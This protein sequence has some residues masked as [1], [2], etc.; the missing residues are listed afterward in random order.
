MKLLTKFSLIFT[1]VFGLGL[2]AAGY[3]CY[4]LL[5]RNAREQ[6]LYQAHLMMDSAAAVRHYTNERIKPL[7]AG[8]AS[9]AGEFRPETVPAFA[10]TEIFRELRKNYPDYSY[11]E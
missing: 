1:T 5:Q 8:H 10:A 7:V 9:A 11:K 4:G 2:G 6:V 3:V